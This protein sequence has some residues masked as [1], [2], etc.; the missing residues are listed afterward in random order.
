VFSFEA[1]VLK[2]ARE[3]LKIMRN[4]IIVMTLMFASAFI[5][6]PSS[7]YAAVPENTTSVTVNEFAPQIRVQVG[8]GRRGR[9]KH[10]NRGRHRGW[11]NQ[12]NRT[13]VVRQ[14]YYRNGRKYVR[15]IRV[16]G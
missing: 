5:I 11:E 16:R 10:M 9:N 2:R 12:R 3:I 8:R 1:Q 13:R 4:K 7:S 14:V 6:L 15:Y